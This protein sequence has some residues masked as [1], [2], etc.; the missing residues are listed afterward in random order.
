MLIN[1]SVQYFPKV[2]WDSQ[3]VA[4]SLFTPYNLTHEDTNFRVLPDSDL[5]T[6]ADFNSGPTDD[7]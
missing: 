3:K 6:L 1:C 4:L 7:R 2:S 5:R